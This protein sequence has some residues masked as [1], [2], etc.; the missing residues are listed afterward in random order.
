VA[1]SGQVLDTLARG[2]PGGIP[3]ALGHAQR[4]GGR[5]YRQWGDGDRDRAQPNSLQAAEG[6]YG[7]VVG[8]IAE[9]CAASGRLRRRFVRWK[10]DRVL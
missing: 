2:V 3:H 4:N 1:L 7:Q 5:Q 9:R 8:V 6:A 10:S